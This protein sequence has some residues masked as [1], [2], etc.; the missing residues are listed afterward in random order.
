MVWFVGL[1]G[2]RRRRRRRRGHVAGRV[3]SIVDVVVF[4]M[5]GV[6]GG[7]RAREGKGREGESVVGGGWVVGL[8][9]WEGG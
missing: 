1:G 2:R 9:G 4:D 3:M 5:R 6:K 7:G 8:G